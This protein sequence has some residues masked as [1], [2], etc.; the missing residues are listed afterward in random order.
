MTRILA[1]SDIHGAVPAVRTLVD[2]EAGSFD[3]VV[4]AG[5]IGPCPA[6][7][8]LALEPLGCPVFY[9]YGNWDNR[10]EYDRVFSASFSHLHGRVATA[11]DLSF[12]GFSGCGANWGRNPHWLELIA[13]VQSSHRGIL[14]ELE[15]A[16]TRDRTLRLQIREAC[17]SAL[18]DL[19][20]RADDK[21]RKGYRARVHAIETRWLRQQELQCRNAER[22][23]DSKSYAAYE[24]AHEAALTEVEMRNR[25][26]LL[27]VS[28]EHLLEPARTVVVTHD[29]LYRLPEDFPGLG[30]HLF[31]HR[32]GFKVT[33]Q[34][35]TIFVNVSTLDPTAQFDAQY[36]II[37]WSENGGYLVTGKHLPRIEQLFDECLACKEAQL[38]TEYG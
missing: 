2:V 22:I 33:K 5:D 13:D 19:A 38:E 8:F 27:R 31:G 1:F 14:E 36:A 37:E 34:R 21:R 24:S 30:A 17:E 28:R 20:S 6:E 10:L 7:F 23:M 3:A 25:A 12:V 29:R 9:I 18:C 11:G 16:K 4:V 15:S 26:A 32:H 35:G